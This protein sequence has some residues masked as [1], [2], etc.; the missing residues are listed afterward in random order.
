MSFADEVVSLGPWYHKINFEGTMS[1]EDSISSEEIYQ[2]LR[3]LLNDRL[4]E[5]IFLDVG[6]NDGYYTSRLGVDKAQSVVGVEKSEK[7]IKQA[8]F[9]RDYLIKDP[10]SRKNVE[11]VCDTFQNYLMTILQTTRFNCILALSVIYHQH[12]QYEVARLF[13][14]MTH[15]IITRFRREDRGENEIRTGEIFSSHL[16]KFKFVETERKEFGGR[17]FVRYDRI[18]NL[19]LEKNHSKLFTDEIYTR[20]YDEIIGKVVGCRHPVVWSRLEESLRKNID[21]FVTWVKPEM[22]IHRN[23]D[24]DFEVVFRNKKNLLESVKEHGLL[25]PIVGRRKKNGYAID[26]GNHRAAISKI[27]KLDRVAIIG[28]EEYDDKGNLIL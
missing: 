8:Y 26:D 24:P 11:F 25:C 21:D 2:E 20:G 22:L 27:L 3:P 15:M 1:N 19:R 28:M 7:C 23:M 9:L 13:S 4:E 6:C 10:S 14:N 12:D 16:R 17:D 5:S 18:G